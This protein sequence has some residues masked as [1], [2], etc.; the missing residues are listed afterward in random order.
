MLLLLLLPLFSTATI[1]LLYCSYRCGGVA[2]FGGD[3]GPYHT[4]DGV[5]RI[6]RRGAHEVDRY[7][8]EDSHRSSDE[9]SARNGDGPIPVVVPPVCQIMVEF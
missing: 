5:E 6:E 9:N 2:T 7:V 4:R 1:L 3:S 8:R